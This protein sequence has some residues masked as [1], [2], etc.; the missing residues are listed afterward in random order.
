[1]EIA[2]TKVSSRGQIVI[3]QEMRSKLK[4]GEKLVIIE[5]ENQF[6]LKKSSEM[7]KHFEEDLEFAKRTNKKLEEYEKG[8]GN[9]KTLSK[10]EFL[11]ELERW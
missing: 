9:F 7:S 1:M 5:S 2:T 4:T 6:I 3:P 8:V 10:D 11:E